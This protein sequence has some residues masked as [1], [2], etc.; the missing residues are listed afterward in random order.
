M[1]NKTLILGIVGSVR[2]NHKKMSELKNM[3]LTSNNSSE[4]NESINSSGIIYS[5]TDI[6]IAH[7]LLGAK[8]QSANIELICITDLFSHAKLDLYGEVLNHNSIDDLNDIDTLSIDKEKYLELIEYVK[9]CDGVILGTPVYFGDRSSVANKFLQLTQKHNLLKGKAFGVVSVGAKRN[10]GQ[11]TANI[12]SLYES[13]MQGSIAIG[14]GPKTSQYGGTVWAGDAGKATED[15]FGLETSYGTG[16]QV[17]QL[18]E[19]LKSGAEQKRA[20]DD[21]VKVIALLTMD[22]KNEDYSKVVQEYF[23]DIDRDRVDL[24]IYSIVD[25][26]IYRCIAC[27]ICPAPKFIE[28]YKD[29]E[30]PYHCI[31]QT[32]R[33]SMRDIQE[34]L[35]KTDGIVL[36]G[37]NSNDDITYKYQAFM[38]RT[39]F[40]RHDDYELTNI[41]ITGLLINELGATSNPIFNVKVLTSFIRHNTFFLT[42]Q[43]IVLKDKEVIYATKFDDLIEILEIVKRGRSTIDGMAVS[44]KATGYQEKSLDNTYKIRK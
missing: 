34:R 17:A 26:D 9:L 16:R 12:Y 10:G 32:N 7:A 42:P 44:Y 18:S 3:I 28:K 36:I 39:R 11:E 15:D 20:K 23:K 14:N 13:L 30:Y 31:V 38:E 6:S 41:P 29:D 27:D 5:N 25:G 1:S 22:N 19:I 33:D 35:V 37:V 4:L 43:E 40:I 24:E 21:K 2:S 8:Q